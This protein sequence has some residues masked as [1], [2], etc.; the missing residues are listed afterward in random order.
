V[1]A[2]LGLNDCPHIV[3]DF[4]RK[5]RVVEFGSSLGC[6]E[7]V[8]HCVDPGIGGFLVG[9]ALGIF[10]CLGAFMGGVLAGVVVFTPLVAASQFCRSRVRWAAWTWAGAG[11]TVAAGIG[12]AGM[13]VVLM[14]KGTAEY[15]AAPL[16]ACSTSQPLSLPAG[17]LMRLDDIGLF[18]G[19]A[20]G[21]VGYGIFAFREDVR[22]LWWKWRW[23]V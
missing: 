23:R 18:A 14:F 20:L 5:L 2:G 4:N 12:W 3:S 17:L 1:A 8:T 10:S 22:H 7:M 11:I 13:V 9:L 6:H 19:F 21:V 15:F 16:V